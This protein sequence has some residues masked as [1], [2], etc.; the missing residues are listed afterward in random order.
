MPKPDTWERLLKLWAYVAPDIGGYR[1]RGRA[2]S[3]HII[4]VQ[5][6]DTLHSA[7]KTVRL[8]EKKLLSSEEDWE[9][10]GG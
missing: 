8:G 6:Q 2:A 9:F 10:L 3:F 1:F 7:D 4:P 5:G